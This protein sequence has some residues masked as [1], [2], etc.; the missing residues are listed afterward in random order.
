M[1]T[2]KIIFDE[3]KVNEEHHVPKRTQAAWALNLGVLL[4]VS[5][6]SS[7][8]VSVCGKQGKW[9]DSSPSPPPARTRLEWTDLCVNPALGLLLCLLGRAPSVSNPPV[10]HL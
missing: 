6:D 1:G 3:E 8:L 7:V 10:L 9:M 5:T 2:H 4:T